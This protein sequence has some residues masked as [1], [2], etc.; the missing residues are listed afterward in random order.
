MKN[1]IIKTT[2]NTIIETTILIINDR[3][4]FFGLLLVLLI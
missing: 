4:W 3:V 2:D 1:N